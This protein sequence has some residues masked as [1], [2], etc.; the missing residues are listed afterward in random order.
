MVFIIQYVGARPPAPPLKP[1]QSERWIVIFQIIL[2]LSL[3]QCYGQT[4]VNYNYWYLLLKTI[5]IKFKRVDNFQNDTVDFDQKVIFRYFFI[6]KK[7][8]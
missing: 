8:S 1:L 5:W 4:E 2:K 7:K 3:F 6:D